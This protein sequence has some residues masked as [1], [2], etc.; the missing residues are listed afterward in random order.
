MKKLLK[1]LFTAAAGLFLIIV[2][3]FAYLNF[4]YLPQK[5]KAEG[6]RYLEEK[7]KGQVQAIS[8]QYVPFKGVRLKEVSFLSKEKK[9]ILAIDKLYLNVSLLPLITRRELV[10][11]I[12]LYPPKIKSPFTFDGVY[13]IKERTLE[14]DSK[15]RN[16]SFARKQ[17]IIA[18]L[19]VLIDKDEK[20][21]I[22][23]RL[24]SPDLNVQASLYI[25]D[26]DL[27]IEKFSGQILQSSFDIIGDVQNL[28]DPSLNIYGNLVLNLAGLKGINPK[29]IKLP[30]KL[31]MEGRCLGEVFVS[32]SLNN[33][34]IGLKMKAEQIRFKQTTIEG[35]SL[36]AEMKDK[37]V[38]LSKFYARLCD[39]EVNLEGAC[40]LDVQG[41]PASLDLNVFNLCLNTLIKEITGKDTPLQGRFFSLGRLNAPLKDPQSLEGKLWLSAAGSNLLQLPVFTGIAEVLRLPEMLNIKFKEASGNFLIGRRQIETSDFK[42]AGNDIVIYFKGYTDFVGNLGFDIEPTFSPAFLSAPKI[43]NILGI[44]T[45]PTTGKFLGEI[46]LKGT[47]KEPRY[48]FKPISPDKLFR[49]GIEEGLKQL[50]KFKKKE[51]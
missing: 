13:R 49:G 1:I 38:S 50:F 20:S 45:N 34:Q 26:K 19:N 12:D 46:K 35:L 42:I 11:R 18:K 14:V 23:L 21:D 5:V 32:S 28:S 43:G 31:N 3:A 15:I 39:G 37:R 47:L 27:R 2:G 41:F 40:K 22:N 33:P 51:D 48:T 10:F 6:P 30:E 25:E 44:L 17:T 9:P 7:T 16:D 36:I 4:V 29:Y 8:I 24:S